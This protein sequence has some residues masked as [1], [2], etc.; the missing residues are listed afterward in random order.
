[1][2]AGPAVKRTR[3]RARNHRWIQM[4]RTAEVEPR[5]NTDAHRWFGQE[6]NR[7]D[8]KGAKSPDAD[9]GNQPQMN[10]DDRNCHPE[11]SRGV[12][13]RSDEPQ[14]IRTIQNPKSKIQDPL[15]PDPGTRISPPRHQEESGSRSAEAETNT[16]C[17]KS[18]KGAD[19]V[20]CQMSDVRCRK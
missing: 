18:T 6:V 1:M 13:S 16:K 14:R 12:S 9:I 17:T 7:K 11:R 3:T 15:T 5:M 2:P 19:D 8:A 4:V 10:A 20:R